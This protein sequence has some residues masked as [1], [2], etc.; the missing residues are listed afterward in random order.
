MP[1]SKPMRTSRAPDLKASSS[2]SKAP[3]RKPS[4]T[5]GHAWEAKERARRSCFKASLGLNDADV[6]PKEAWKGV[7]DMKQNILDLYSTKPKAQG[8]KRTAMDQPSELHEAG[9]FL[10]CR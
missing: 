3:V 1:A 4:Q 8:L 9:V 5:S 7:A 6:L 10:L 2:H